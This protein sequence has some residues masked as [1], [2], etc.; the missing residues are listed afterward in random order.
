MQSLG[1][2]GPISSIGDI[3]ADFVHQRFGQDSYTRIDREIIRLKRGAGFNIFNQEESGKFVCLIESRACRSSVKCSSVDIV[4]LFDSDWNPMNDIRALRKIKIDSQFE[5]LKILRLYSSFTVEEQILI[6][7][8]Q[9]V[10]LDSNIETVNRTTCHILLNWGAHYLFN[11]LDIMHS[12]R[13]PVSLLNNW[14]E[15]SLL[16]DVFLELSA[17][18]PNKCEASDPT[19][20]SI[21]S[22]VQQ[23]EGAYTSNI[24]LL[25]EVELQS[26]ENFIVIKQ[27]MD[28]EPPHAFWTNLLEGREHRWKY[29]P[30]PSARKRKTVQYPIRLP[31]GF[32]SEVNP[33]ENKRSKLV[34]NTANIT[35]LT[36]RLT[37]KRKVPAPV[38]DSHVAGIGNC[39]QFGLNL[40]L[41]K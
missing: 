22:R 30:G 27:F 12:C 41:S 31:E 20:C 13:A 19:S 26:M 5:P 10:T 29:L 7:A 8:K 18:L 25:G 40:F 9:G 11:K 2:S 34:N 16:E 35:S 28:N 21:I 14:S 3:L 37:N 1:G 23:T 38:E 24:L 4:I 17:I 36:V 32:D 33:V 39:C 6:L 15:E